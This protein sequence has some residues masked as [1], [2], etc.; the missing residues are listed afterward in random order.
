MPDQKLLDLMLEND[1]NLIKKDEDATFM[2]GRCGEYG[3]LVPGMRANHL[4]CGPVYFVPSS[5]DK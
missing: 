1:R 2:C 5:A 3:P 4:T